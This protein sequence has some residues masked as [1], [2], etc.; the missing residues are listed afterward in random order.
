MGTSPSKK[1]LGA[2][3]ARG[4]RVNVWLDPDAAGRKAVAKLMP[5]LQAFGIEAR[6]IRSV[7]DPKLV[8][9]PEI[10]ELLWNTHQQVATALR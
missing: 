4:C 6:D 8:H 3:A 1:L 9:I 7:R 5:Q 2:L 10:K